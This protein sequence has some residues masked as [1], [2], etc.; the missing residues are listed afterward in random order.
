[1]TIL[2]IQRST[3]TLSETPGRSRVGFY[4]F[5]VCFGTPLGVISTRVGDQFVILDVG[6]ACGI[7][8]SIFHKTC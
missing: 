2:F 5:W 8:I 3:G 6:M 7:R 4:T 1:M